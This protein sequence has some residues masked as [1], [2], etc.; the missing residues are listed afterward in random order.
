MKIKIKNISIKKCLKK[1]KKLIIL[2]NPNWIKLIKI[3]NPLHSS[4]NQ[5]LVYYLTNVPFA[6]Q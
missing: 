2:K 4:P 6:F 1:L 5:V 3:Q